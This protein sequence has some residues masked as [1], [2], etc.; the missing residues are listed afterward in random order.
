MPPHTALVMARHT[1]VSTPASTNV[2]STAFSC[3]ITW[4]ISPDTERPCVFTTEL[5]AVDAK[6]P[7][8]IAPH[9][10]PTQCT[11]TTSSASSYVF[12]FILSEH[13]YQQSTPATPPTAID[14]I[15]VTNPDA[16]V[17]ATRPATAPDA[18]PSIVGLPFTIHSASIHVSAAAAAPVLV[19]TNAL[20]ASPFD[21]S[22]LPALKPN[23]PTHSI[24]APTSVNGR[25]CGGIGSEPKPMR[26]PSQSAVTSAEN[27]ELMCTTVPPAKSSA[28]HPPLR[29][30]R[31]L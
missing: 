15:G 2:T 14:A 30:M 11:P 7:V 31:P 28:P 12:I 27:P 17:I 4:P 13:A 22:A 18:A 20:T 26:L 29:P 24:A 23:Q 21:A 1:G 25:L 10:P 16:G 8:A 19:A 6:S 3:T 5:T 9:V